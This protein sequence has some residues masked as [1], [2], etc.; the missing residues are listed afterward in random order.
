MLRHHFLG[1]SLAVMTAAG[2]LLIS[3]A[4]AQAAMAPTTQPA[5]SMIQ[6][7]DC[8]AGFHIGPVGACVGDEAPPRRDVIIEH[9][10]APR[11]I[12]RRA[13][14][15]DCRTKTVKRTNGM[16]DSMTKTKTRCD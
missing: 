10:D 2:A 1:G 11:V 13:T 6:K 12:E 9:H 4:G 3:A 14:D 16:G 15:E 5:S 8:A 7:A